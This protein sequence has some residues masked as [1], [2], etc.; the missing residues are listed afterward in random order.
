MK[1]SFE[2]KLSLNKQ[3]V[4]DLHTGDMSGVRGG[5]ADATSATPRCEYT[6]PYCPTSLSPKCEY[7]CLCTESDC[8]TAC[9]SDPCC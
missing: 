8:M 7:T 4:A 5:T 6:C 2:K 3:T 1:K 9:G